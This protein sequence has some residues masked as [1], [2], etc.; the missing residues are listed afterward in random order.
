MEEK[1]PFFH[2][3]KCLFSALRRKM[4]V[5]GLH[6]PGELGVKA[7]GSSGYDVVI[8]CRYCGETLRCSDV[9]NFRPFL[10]KKD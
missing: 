7:R 9:E 5:L 8:E 2:R 6:T 1:Q 3:V 10:S 4:C